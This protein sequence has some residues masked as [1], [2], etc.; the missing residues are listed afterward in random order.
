MFTGREL[1]SEKERSQ[2]GTLI[3]LRGKAAK[4]ALF[5]DKR[6]GTGLD[7]SEIREQEV[8]LGLRRGE[9]WPEVQPMPAEETDTETYIAKVR[10]QGEL[11]E[12]QVKQ[13]PGFRKGRH[14]APDCL[15]PATQ[16]FF[17]RVIGERVEAEAEGWFQRARTEL[18]AKRKELTVEVTSPSAVLT[19]R[20]FSFEIAYTLLAEDPGRYGGQQILH[21]LKDACWEAEAFERL[22]AGQF[23]EII[24]E[25]TKGVQVEAVIDAVEELDGEQGLSVDYPSN[26]AHCVLRVAGVDA[27]VHCDGA[28]LAMRFP[29]AGSPGELVRAFAEMRHAF[30]LSGKA[31]LLK[32]LR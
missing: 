23:N 22:F 1:R 28:S 5:Y 26:C 20:D 11:E 29:Q 24:F 31:P 10:L 14:T 25:L 8:I 16:S 27:E 30:R 19:G 7:G 12:G 2:T 32:M 4:V 3:L 21:D 13:L 17:A 18:R 9:C 6:A 15:S